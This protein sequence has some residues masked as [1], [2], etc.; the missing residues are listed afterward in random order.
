MPGFVRLWSRRWIADVVATCV[1]AMVCSKSTVTRDVLPPVSPQW[2][3]GRWGVVVEGVADPADHAFQPGQKKTSCGAAYGI[4][5][6]QA[7]D[8]MAA[9]S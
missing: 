4:C 7:L 1:S 3:D 2:D 5:R 9:V 8:C 6:A